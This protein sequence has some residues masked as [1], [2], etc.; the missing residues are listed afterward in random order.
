MTDIERLAVAQAV[1]KAVAK[2]VST[3]DADSLRS[4]AD[5]DLLDMYD[6]MGVAR[7]DLKVAGEKVGSYSVRVG[8]PTEAKVERE[9]SV[10]DLERVYQWATTDAAEEYREWCVAHA[11][12]FAEYAFREYGEVADGCEVVERVTPGEPG[13]VLGTT[14][15][16]DEQKVARA[17][18]AQ[19]PSTVAGLLDG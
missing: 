11:G 10:G 18:G 3:K 15:K 12:E 16:V 6:R 14:L 9:L 1:Y 8:K 19:L 4:K 2:V 7:V 17:L 13:R 5:A